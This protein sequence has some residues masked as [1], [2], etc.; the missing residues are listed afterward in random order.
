MQSNA[1]TVQKTQSLIALMKDPEMI[2][3]FEDLTTTIPTTQ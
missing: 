2:E 3:V 1:D